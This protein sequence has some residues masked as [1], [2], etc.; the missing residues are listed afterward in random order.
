MKSYIPVVIIMATIFALSHT[1]GDQ[2][3]LPQNIFA[4]DKFFHTI[5]YTALGLSAIF[6]VRT[7]FAQEQ[8]ST[9]LYVLLFCLA[10]GISD[11]F[12]QSFIAYRT[13]SL[14][15]VF[16]DITGGILAVSIVTLWLQK[17]KKATFQTDGKSL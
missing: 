7:R 10:Y 6:A 5:A 12:H 8:R 11:E 15:D 1:P 16:A 17:Q 3:P 2:L 4:L 14:L 9:S 13:P